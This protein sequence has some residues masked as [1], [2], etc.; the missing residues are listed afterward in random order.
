MRGERLGRGGKKNNNRN[1]SRLDKAAE[2][3]PAASFGALGRT[4]TGARPSSPLPQP[5]EREIR[6]P[7]VTSPAISPEKDD[8]GEISPP[9]PPES[10][11]ELIL[12]EKRPKHRTKEAGEG[13]RGGARAD[14]QPLPGTPPHPGTPHLPPPLPY[15]MPPEP[16]ATSLSRQTTASPR[17]SLPATASSPRRPAQSLSEPRPAPD[18]VS[19]PHRLGN[20]FSE[21]LQGQGGVRLGGEGQ[22]QRG[23]FMGHYWVYPSKYTRDAKS[24]LA[25][26]ALTGSKNSVVFCLLLAGKML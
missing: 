8:A 21:L 11:W 12:R 6:R 7:D 18:G 13:G 16:D 1:K 20:Y 3:A 17:F 24:V 5:F 15:E 4:S 10:A 2:L 14:P 22:C 9:P 19:D 25:K 26:L 23:S